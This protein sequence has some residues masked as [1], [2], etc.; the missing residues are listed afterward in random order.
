MC[1]CQSIIIVVSESQLSSSMLNCTHQTP[2][3]K[4]RPTFV[5]NLRERDHIPK[6]NYSSTK[7]SRRRITTA[8]IVRWCRKMVKLEAEWTANEEAS[9][10]ECARWHRNTKPL[11]TRSRWRHLLHTDGANELKLIPS[12]NIPVCRQFSS[13][14][15]AASLCDTCAPSPSVHAH[16]SGLSGLVYHGAAAGTFSSWQTEWVSE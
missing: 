1:R 14:C 2:V 11:A 12:R 4:S 15:F 9:K 13:T 3:A 6:C 8:K 10:R 16:V 7:D 5:S